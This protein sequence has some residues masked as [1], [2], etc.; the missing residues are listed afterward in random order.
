[1][2]KYI[3]SAALLFCYIISN[4]QTFSG[5]GLPTSI[6]NSQDIHTCYNATVTGV[7]PIGSSKGLSRVCFTINHTSVDDLE[8]LLQAPD[9]TYVPLTIQNGGTGDNYTSTCF[10]ATATSPIKFNSAPFTG[11]YLPEG[12]LGAVNNGQNADGIWKLC[13]LDRKG[14]ATGTLQNWSITFSNTPAPAPPSFPNCST[15]IPSSSDCAS[16]TSICDFNGACGSTINTP[17][18]TWAALTAACCFGINNNSFVKF[19]ASSSNVSFSVWTPSSQAGFNNRNGGI[20][21]FFFSTPSCGGTVTSFGCYNRIYPYAPNGKELA[22]VVYATGLTPGNTYYLM[23]DGVNGDECNFRIAANSGVNILS[24]SPSDPSICNGETVNLTASGGTGNTYTWSSTSSNVTFSAS[25]GTSI[26]AN[27]VGNNTSITTIP[28]TV[29]NT[30]ATGC[31]N[32]KTINITVNP[33]PSTPTFN[34]SQ[35]T[36]ST[37]T[38]SATVSNPTGTTFEYS[39]NGGAYQSSPTFNNLNQGT[40]SITARN[41]SSNCISSA[42]N[43]TINA[44]PTAPAAPSLNIIQPTCTV[45]TGS[46]TVNIPTGNNFEY[47]LNGGT[48]QSS[49]AFNG[50]NPGNYSITVRNNSTNCISAASTFVITA[51]RSSPNAPTFTIIQPTCSTPIGSITIS[52]PVG[53]NLEY[54]LNGGSYQSSPTFNNLIPGT[55]SATVKNTL[56]NCV[57]APSSFTINN[58][59]A[60]TPSYVYSII[61]PTCSNPTGGIVIQQ[62][63]GNNYEYNINN[64]T[65]QS[66]PSFSN[67]TSGNYTTTVRDKI[68]GCVSPSSTFTVKPAPVVPVAPT[69]NSTQPTCSIP[70][71]S[72]TVSTPTGANFEYNL[73]GGT[74]QS[75]ALFSNLNPS[76]YSI[77]VK[78]KTSGCE[79][80]ATSVTINA[81]PSAPQA[82]TFNITQPT[83]SLS[84]GS[85]TIT[86]PT[87]NNLEYS[88]NGGTYQTA[89]TFSS[90]TPGNYSVTVRNSTTNCVSPA[91]TFTINAAPSA[92][93]APTFNIT[94]P[95]CS[96]LTGSVIITNPTGANLEYSLNGGTYQTA[97]TFSG[98]NP[99]IYTV[100]AKDNLSNCTSSAASFTINPA[101]GIPPTPE[102]TITVKPTCSNQV[103]TIQITNSSGSNYS[104]GINGTYQADPVFAGLAVGQPYTFTIRNLTTG[105]TSISSSISIDPPVCGDDLFV[106]NAFSPNGDGK[107]DILFVRG[108]SIANMQFLVYN[109]WGEKVFESN[110]PSSGWNGLFGGKPQPVGVY[111][112]VLRVTKTNGETINKKGSVTLIR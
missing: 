37:P 71:G 97:A 47:S 50:L 65:Y 77:R 51:D 8:V 94:Q 18:K 4:A 108:S 81:A 111:V 91:A 90:L 27:P 24:I 70:T 12:H 109:Q 79:S 35:P 39:L 1:M 63:V 98:L 28:V 2:R 74:Y 68:T 32:S 86:N 110:A 107:N 80:N 7:G 31:P 82:P 13:I 56:V 17:F 22:N 87:G 104:Y 102:L 3:L 48:Y 10:S 36:C 100:T 72:I 105:C 60:G 6:P 5:S 66:T 75:S 84:T 40:Y 103:G 88:L 11:T 44:A 95:T 64:G 9:G 101:P 112:Y 49:P 38:G 23:I 33:I 54:S 89:A 42:G 45:L 19:I 58:I 67:L 26:T 62:P 29:N 93:Q 16:A 20:Q 43:F 57:S 99:G 34:I 15:Q 85:V 92:P 96:L 25:S 73:N 41:N 106:P 61:D 83:C 53:N 14:A 30:T 55:Y 78:D 46:A 21:M 69:T 76:T 52:S 59:P